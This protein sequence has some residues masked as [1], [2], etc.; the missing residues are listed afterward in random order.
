MGLRATADTAGASR[1]NSPLQRGF[2]TRAQT[3]LVAIVLSAFV[4]LWVQL[5]STSNA[6][7]APREHLGDFAPRTLDKAEP[8]ARHHRDDTNVAVAPSTISALGSSLQDDAERI[9]RTSRRQIHI[10]GIYY[11]RCCCRRFVSPHEIRLLLTA[12][13]RTH[14]LISKVSWRCTSTAL[15]PS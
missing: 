5:S 10:T 1:L 4:S 14:E 3:I 15:V 7:R 12:V 11:C 2:G 6:R 13:P 8:L 9:T